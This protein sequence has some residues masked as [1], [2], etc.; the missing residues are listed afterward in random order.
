MHLVHVVP[1]LRGRNPALLTVCHRRCGRRDRCRYLGGVVGGSGRAGAVVILWK[2]VLLLLWLLLLRWLLVLREVHRA[3][4]GVARECVGRTDG[5]GTLRPRLRVPSRRS[6][7]AHVCGVRV[8]YH[9]RL[10]RNVG[11]CSCCWRRRLRH[12]VLHPAGQRLPQ[13]AGRH[14]TT[15][16]GRRRAS[17]F[18]G[19]RGRPTVG[20]HSAERRRWRRLLIVT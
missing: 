12:G 9:G 7:R 1:L 16:T 13:R 10:L 20:A 15:V 5:A 19:G 6:R 3:A 8:G 2:N 11:C 4:A 18:G 14:A 17:N